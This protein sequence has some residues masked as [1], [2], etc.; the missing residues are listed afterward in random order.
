VV[1]ILITSCLLY[2]S[3]RP[4]TTAHNEVD[5]LAFSGIPDNPFLD[6][7]T[8]P[9]IPTLDGGHAYYGETNERKEKKSACIHFIVSDSTN[10]VVY[11]FLF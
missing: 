11:I 6:S 7:S 2:I 8:Y 9:L 3:G 1:Y 5:F 4:F 10:N